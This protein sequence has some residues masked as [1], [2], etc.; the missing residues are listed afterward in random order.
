MYNPKAF[1]WNIGFE[2]FIFI[3]S[4]SW[5]SIVILYW[6]DLHSLS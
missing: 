6:S 4:E 3:Y 1:H 2:E 5:L